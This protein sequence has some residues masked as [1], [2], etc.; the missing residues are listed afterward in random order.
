VSESYSRSFSLREPWQSD[1]I[2]NL[3][4]EK[5]RLNGGQVFSYDLIVESQAEQTSRVAW[6]FKLNDDSLD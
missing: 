6:N 2:E 4:D 1:P 3:A 5:M